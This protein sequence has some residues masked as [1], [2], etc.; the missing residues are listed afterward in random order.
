VRGRRPG[1][2]T[3]IRVPDRSKVAGL[4]PREIARRKAKIDK[5]SAGHLAM[6]AAYRKAAGAKTAPAKEGE[7]PSPSPQSSALMELAEQHEAIAKDMSAVYLKDAEELYAMA[8]TAVEQTGDRRAGRSMLLQ[9]DALKKAA[10]AHAS[11][12]KLSAQAK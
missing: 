7:A 10:E 9:A 2:P 1:A 5:A 8:K 12:V 6:A 4:S 11:I 3:P